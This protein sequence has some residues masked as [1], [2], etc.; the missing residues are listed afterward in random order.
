MKDVEK[1]KNQLIPFLPAEDWL[2]GLVFRG[3][4]EPWSDDF[5]DEG[6]MIDFALKHGL[7]Q[8]LYRSPVVDS[9]TEV[10]RNK[11]KKEYF[12]NLARNAALQIVGDEVLQKL[13]SKG[14]EA[15]LLK[16]SFLS[17]VVYRDSA[18][19][20]M[21]DIDILVP[22]G[23]AEEAFTMLAPDGAD[24]VNMDKYGH[25]LP[26]FMY[27]GVLLE[28]HKSLFAVNLKYQIPTAII[29]QKKEIIPDG[30]L[31]AMHPLHLLAHL[32]LHIYYSYRNGG[33]RLG[34][35]YDLKLCFEYYQNRFT[36]EEIINFMSA[37]DLLKPV[38]RVLGLLHFLWPQS[39]L[40]SD[41]FEVPL[42]DVAEMASF[43]KRHNGGPSGLKY[44]YSIA[45]E[46]LK[47]SKDWKARLAFMK[48]LVL[49]DKT[50]SH[51][52][53]LF[54]LWYLVKS[55]LRM[56]LFRLFGR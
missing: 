27:R 44:G 39:Y 43:I 48:H 32:L 2:I 30:G 31:N 5:G 52:H 33:V 25:H 16:G 55:S 50:G 41:D 13:R 42:N 51:H 18:L 6:S 56:L 53:L 29:W 22:S 26:G 49:V 12:S 1:Y 28:I 34:W 15:M 24:L 7:G 46:R 20:P 8:I 36:K 14:I 54:R 23:R 47:Y 9:L 11:L 19:R 38:S 17:R 45:W 4:T 35:F 37:N 3:E 40:G 21:S 10:G